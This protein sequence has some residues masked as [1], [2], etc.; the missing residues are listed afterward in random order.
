MII[1]AHDVL[2]S[3]DRSNAGNAKL[4]GLDSL[5]GKNV[6]TNYSI[7]LSAFYITYVVSSYILLIV[8]RSNSLS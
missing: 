5:L 4:Q 7:V 2:R 6:D 8:R 3:L 1:S